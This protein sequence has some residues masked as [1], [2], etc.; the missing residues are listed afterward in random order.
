MAKALASAASNRS[1]SV[2]NPRR[3]W[4]QSKA[5]AVTPA[6]FAHHASFSA[7]SAS[8]ATTQPPMMSLW[9]LIYFVVD[10]S[11]ISA[12]RSS[13]RI[14]S[15]ERKVLSTTLIAPAALAAAQMVR[16]STTRISGLDGLSIMTRAGDLASASSSAVAS[17]WST[18][19]T[20]IRPCAARCVSRRCVPP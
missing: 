14:R 18:N 12:P 2:R 13:G 3:V 8:F 5:L 19:S 1:A 9:P 11:A 7:T 4:W 17:D 10:C 20:R 6:Q 15:G 16:T